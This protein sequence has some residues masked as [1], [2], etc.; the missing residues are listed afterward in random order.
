MMG[1]IRGTF[2]ICVLFSIVASGQLKSISEA[3]YDKA[4][5]VAFK[6]VNSTFRRTI[7][8]ETTYKDSKIDTIR[9]LTKDSFLNDDSRWNW[10]TERGDQVI[11]SLQIIYLGKYEYRKEGDADWTK[12]CVKDCS[13]SE[14]DSKS[15]SIAG[16]QELPKVREYMSLV[17]EINGK[18]ANLYHFYRVYQRGLMLNFYERRIWIGTNGLIVAEDSTNSDMLPTNLM[19]RETVTYQYDPKDLVPLKAPID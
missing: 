8:V 10:V 9:T 1:F 14:K 6:N 18:Q 16:G 12:R 11:E 2:I 19:S 17:T 15:F 3:E 4:K 13:P 7:S 5:D